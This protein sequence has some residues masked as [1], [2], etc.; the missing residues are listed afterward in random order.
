MGQ[1][2]AL[3]DSRSFHRSQNAIFVLKPPNRSQNAKSVS[4]A[5]ICPNLRKA[6]G[7]ASGDFRNDKN[8]KS[9]NEKVTTIHIAKSKQNLY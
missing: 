4:K 1:K 2:V 6:D 3:W 8:L 5:A 7:Q 9:D